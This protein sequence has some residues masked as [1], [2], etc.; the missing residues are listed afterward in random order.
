MLTSNYHTAD[1]N[2]SY[3]KQIK[4]HFFQVMVGYQEEYYKSVQLIG[5]RKDLFTNSI[6]TLH[7]AYNSQ[8]IVD[9]AL[10]QWATQGIFSRLTYNYQ[11]KY[12]IEFNGRYDAHSK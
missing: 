12:L 3:F 4:K 1:L 10:S 11:E 9:D 5:D 8:P 7:T 6:P 2:A